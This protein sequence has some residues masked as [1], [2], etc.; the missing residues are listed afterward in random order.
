MAKLSAVK[1]PKKSSDTSKQTGELPV[2]GTLG[3]NIDLLHAVR[4]NIRHY[5]AEIKK[6]EEQK[7][8]IEEAIQA[9]MKA[10][11]LDQARG[12][13]ATASVS[14]K[15]VANVSDW[16]KFYTYIGRNKAFHLLQRRVSDTAWREEVESRK[17]KALPGVEAFTK[18]SLNLRSL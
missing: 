7:H 2:S 6:L 1:A 17:G 9:Q 11:G 14:T 5:E 4:E 10:A 8:A 3:E 12:S 13:L 18:T 15:Q 16:D